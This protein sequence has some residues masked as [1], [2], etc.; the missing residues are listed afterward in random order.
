VIRNSFKIAYRFEQLG[1]LRTVVLRQLIPA[2]FGEIRPDDV[3]QMIA[4]ILGFTYFSRRIRII[5]REHI[6]AQFESLRRLLRHGFNHA[7][8]LFQR[9]CGCCK[10]AVVQ[11]GNRVLLVSVRN[12]P[13]RNFFKQGRS[14]EQQRGAKD[15]EK[16]MRDSNAEITCRRI[17]Q[18]WFENIRNDR[19]HRQPNR[20]ADNVERKMH[21]CGAL[22]VLVGSERGYD[23]RY[24]GPDVLS[25]DDRNRRAVRYLSRDGQR[26]QNADGGR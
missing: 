14:R 11:F 8:A 12:K 9:D 4:V 19:E 1:N 23:R 24:A 21:D 17:K 6:H 25:H 22:C 2:E 13:N 20:R 15:V 18:H 26:L 7:L 10:Q 3:L 5:I 16:R